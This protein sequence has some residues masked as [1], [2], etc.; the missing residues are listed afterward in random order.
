MIV[1]P[2]KQVL[3][4]E[5]DTYEISGL[6]HFT[7]P[8]NTYAGVATSALIGS[9]LSSFTVIS[10]SFDTLSSNI[11]QLSGDLYQLSAIVL[12]ISGSI[13]TGDYIMASGDTLTNATFNYNNSKLKLANNST[14]SL[15]GGN[16]SA[17]AATQ[18]WY[19]GKIIVGKESLPGILYEDSIELDGST[20]YI[21]LVDNAELYFG[22]S[23][24]SSIWYDG[25]NLNIDPNL[26]GHGSINL[27]GQMLV[28]TNVIK[29]GDGLILSADVGVT[30]RTKWICDSFHLSALGG[31]DIYTRNPGQNVNVH[32]LL[33]VTDANRGGLAARKIYV[34]ASGTFLLSAD[35]TGLAYVPNI[36][37]S[38]YSGG[39]DS[40]IATKGY[41]DSSLSSGSSYPYAIEL[42]NNAYVGA[43][44][45]GDTRG[46][47][48]LD[49][50]SGRNAGTQ[51]AA[52][53]Y[54]TALGFGNT[55]TGKKSY[56]IGYENTVDSETSMCIGTSSE[57]INGD[58]S[59]SIGESNHISGGYGYIFGYNNNVYGTNWMAYLVGEENYVRSYN[60]WG[61]YSFILGYDNILQ[62]SAY[63]YIMGQGNEVSSTWQEGIYILGKE[64]IISGTTNSVT[65]GF[66]NILSAMNIVDGYV[67]GNSNLVIGTNEDSA[68][69]SYII[70][71]TN[72]L[73]G[74]PAYSSLFGKS[75][76]LTNSNYSYGLGFSNDIINAH[77]SYV[78]GNNCRIES[79]S[80]M[81]FNSY[82]I[83][84]N[85]NVTEPSAF[86]IGTS[87]SNSTSS[88]VEIG[89][90]NA[91]KIAIKKSGSVVMPAS[92]A[93]LS[94]DLPLT[95]QF[96][97]YYD[98]YYSTVNAVVNNGTAI[99][100][101]ILNEMYFQPSGT[102]DIPRGW[103]LN[104]GLGWQV[105]AQTSNC[106]I[107]PTSG[108]VIEKVL[109]PGTTYSLTATDDI[110]IFDIDL[111]TYGS[112]II[113]I[114]NT[115]GH[116]IAEPY[117]YIRGSTT[118]HALSG[119]YIELIA[120]KNNLGMIYSAVE[121]F[122]NVVPV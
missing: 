26:V 4:K 64:N 13:P 80:P 96:S 43:N 122:S 86:A 107:V 50:Q 10:S 83:G 103:W 81:V 114:T 120:T 51:I 3:V 105:V 65:I 58:Y 5:F 36:P 59:Y 110:T 62:D 37:L 75:N 119:E 98:P 72:T 66:G 112:A 104:D 73:S 63:S 68:N 44:K 95:G 23:K 69:N 57:I 94:G 46:I 17:V 9:L 82:A 11:Y 100:E 19:N 54:S 6:C 15:A 90:T 34:D 113:N 7:N 29:W 92:T 87:I 97:L 45:T 116:N 41:V 84:K 25:A 70:G 102:A 108:G 49:L 52:G 35:S 1:T 91:A 88:S 118:L 22:T 32:T 53:N 12:S 85:C 74:G 20:G 106:T 18:S 76:I 39:S 101:I 109:Y 27:M 121:L 33:D 2:T 47:S 28:G 111:D 30:N 93:A 8:D 115:G 71:E 79:D 40:L 38:S 16:L 21:S 56:A 99:D 60:M 48:A 78:L 77:D 61:D 31:M 24:N 117:G 67:L 14:L 42:V 89:P 55:A